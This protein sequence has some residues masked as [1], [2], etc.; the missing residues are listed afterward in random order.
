M[1]DARYDL[2]GIGNAIVDIIFGDV[3]PQAKL[4][5]SFP[6]AC[7]PCIFLSSFSYIRIFVFS[8]FIFSYFRGK[9]ELC[10]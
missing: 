9:F 10:I 8:Y 5:L 3:I 6:K 2:V 4:P 1:Q 7:E